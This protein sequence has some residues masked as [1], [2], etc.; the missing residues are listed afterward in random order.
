MKQLNIRKELKQ[1][2][3]TEHLKN[4]K[5][6]K[7]RFPVS[8]R[9]CVGHFATLCHYLGHSRSTMTQGALYCSPTLSLPTCYISCYF[10]RQ[11]SLMDMWVKIFE[12]FYVIFVKLF[13]D[14]YYSAFGFC[15]GFASCFDH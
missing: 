5:I 6:P 4:K 10:L 13:L 8:L 2:L 7:I 12:G 1:F 11:T 15:G 14:L 9:P 3:Q